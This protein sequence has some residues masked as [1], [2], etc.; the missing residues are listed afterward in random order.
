MTPKPFRAT[1]LRTG[2]KSA[3][4]NWEGWANGNK[5]L[6]SWSGVSPAHSVSPEMRRSAPQV[7]AFHFMSRKRKKKIGGWSIYSERDKMLLELGFPSYSAYLASE[8]WQSIRTRVFK[9]RGRECF[10]CGK[11]AVSVHHN[12]YTRDNLS[13]RRISN[14][15]PVCHQCHKDVELKDGKQKVAP[16]IVFNRF[17]KLINKRATE[18]NLEGKSRYPKGV[19]YVTPSSPLPF[20]FCPS[21]CD[22]TFAMVNLE[23]VMSI[24]SNAG[25]WNRHQLR[26][27]G[28]GWPPRK[29]WTEQFKGD[30]IRLLLSDW[31]IAVANK[32]QEEMDHPS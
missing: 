4:A 10:G 21:K 14:L 32:K 5:G 15:F 13:G 31:E 18:L 25:G 3:L 22:G 27:L 11:F 2:A 16:N 23:M 19:D 28:V 1:I 12:K 24:R 30:G 26:A 17:S 8:L 6:T 20:E 29:G 7:G 9:Q